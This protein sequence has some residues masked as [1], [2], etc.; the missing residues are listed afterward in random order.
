LERLNGTIRQ[1]IAP[2]HR[3]TRG[4]AKCRTALNT[5]AQLFKSYYNL[6]LRHSTLKGRTPTQAAGLTDHCWTLRELLTFNAAATS[7]I[8]QGVP[9]MRVANPSVVCEFSHIEVGNFARQLVAAVSFHNEKEA[10]VPGTLIAIS[11]KH[12]RI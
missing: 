8:M 5:H 6:C 3:K 2:L 12:H 11:T 4:F 10:L 9:L 1:H 7:K